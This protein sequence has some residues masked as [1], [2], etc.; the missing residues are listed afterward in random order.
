MAENDKVCF[1]IGS[2]TR[3]HVRHGVKGGFCQLSHGRPETL[4]RMQRGDWIAYYSGRTS[5]KNGAP[6]QCFTAIGTITGEEVY[7][8]TLKKDFHPYRRDVRFC[9]AGEIDI[10]PLI[11]KLSFI[12]NK[13]FWGLPFRRGYLKVSRTDF[14]R[15]ATPMLGKTFRPTMQCR[16]AATNK[17]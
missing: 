4:R 13:K 9:R 7:R 12:T 5:W 17:K 2:A 8:V 14:R 11:P 6:S 10:H 16:P 15:I 3:D 1:W